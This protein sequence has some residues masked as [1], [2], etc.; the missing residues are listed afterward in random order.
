MEGEAK[1]EKKSKKV[2]GRKAGVAAWREREGERERVRMRVSI[3]SLLSPPHRHPLSSAQLAKQQV[4]PAAQQ[5]S[6]EERLKLFPFF[7]FLFEMTCKCDTSHPEWASCFLHQ[8][9]R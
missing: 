8:F 1:G 7:S 6:F 4:L 9:Q 3:S 2:M 5:I